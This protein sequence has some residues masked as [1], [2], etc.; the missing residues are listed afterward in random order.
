MEILQSDLCFLNCRH[1][2]QVLTT[3][4]DIEAEQDHDNGLY[5]VQSTALHHSPPHPLSR[6]LMEV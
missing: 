5:P 3:Q 2:M 1:K 4:L 6:N